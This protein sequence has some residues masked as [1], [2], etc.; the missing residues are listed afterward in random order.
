MKYLGLFNVY[1]HCS[2][3]Q[4]AT[5]ATWLTGSYCSVLEHTISM[6]PVGS[7]ILDAL[8]WFI[9]PCLVQSRWSFI[10]MRKESTC[11]DS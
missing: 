1:R 6:T 7:S 8:R 3:L 9:V 10:S 2:F 11:M 4:F 5:K